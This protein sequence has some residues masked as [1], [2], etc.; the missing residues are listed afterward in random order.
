M[1]WYLLL[2]IQ[3]LDAWFN[4]WRFKKFG[5]INHSINVAYR[6]AVGIALVMIFH[7]YDARL[8]FFVAGAFSGYKLL[9]NAEY[10][11]LTGK[12]V[13]YI[14][15]T[16]FLDKLQAKIGLPYEVETIWHIIGIAGMITAFYHL[17]WL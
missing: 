1:I 3:A 15:K 16:A 9:F 4:S 12:P 7:I 5:H 8:P 17:D 11:L 2:G 6:I 14:G 10:N 13:D